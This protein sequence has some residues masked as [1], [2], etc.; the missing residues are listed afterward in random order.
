MAGKRLNRRVF[1]AGTGAG[2]VSGSAMATAASRSV[3]PGASQYPVPPAPSRESGHR[4]DADGGYG[5]RSQFARGR[6]VEGATW[7]LTPLQDIFGTITPS[8][9]HFGIHRAGIPT[10]DPDRHTLAVHGLVNTPLR[11][12]MAELH[13][14]PRVTRIHFIEC[15]G[16]SSSEWESPS[17]AN[18]QMTHGQISNSEWTGV[19]LKDVLAET[20]IRPEATWIVAEGSDAAIMSRSIPLEKCLDDSI[21][22]FA[23]NGEELRPDQGFPLRLLNPGYEGNT[24]IKWLRRIQ[25]VDQPYMTRMETRGYTDLQPDGTA[26][27]FSFVM[28]AKSVITFPSAGIRLE[29][30]GFYEITGLAWSGRGRI[31]SVE[32]SLDA[33]RSWESA[34][35]EPPVLPRAFVRFRIPF[36]WNHEDLTIQSRCRDETGYLQPTL[37]QLH[38]ARGQRR[39]DH[40]NA[41]Q[42]WRISRDGEVTNVHA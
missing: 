7:A 26:R 27:Q 5:L 32:V 42:S 23:Q 4:G 31:E 19:R 38:A 9:L 41:I 25:I 39:Q 24:N 35:I 20:G 36:R 2:I 11:F 37:R 34:R 29:S 28:E 3:M 8:G 12:S 13:R 18:I 10:I 40:N 14:F 6:R 16:N 30:P 33:G 17:G 22:A 21:L 1:L 15:A